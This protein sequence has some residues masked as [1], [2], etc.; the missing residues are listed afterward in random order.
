[1]ITKIIKILCFLPFAPFLAWFAYAK[2]K[3]LGGSEYTYLQAL[4]DCLEQIFQN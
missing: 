4:K 1:M 3:E 2:Q